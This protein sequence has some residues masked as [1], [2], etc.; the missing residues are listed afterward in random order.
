MVPDSQYRR[1]SPD[2]HA[3]VRAHR[4]R[5]LCSACYTAA[6]KDG[7][8]IDHEPIK[9]DGDSLLEEAVILATER[10]LLYSELPAVLGV[11]R[12]ALTTAVRR[13]FRRGDERGAILARHNNYATRAVTP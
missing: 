3:G 11:S 12:D 2:E 9:A 5:G 7:S 6:R 4:G 1:M 13:A 8:L 10:R